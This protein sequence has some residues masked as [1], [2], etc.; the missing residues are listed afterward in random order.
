LNSLVNEQ[1]ER[2]EYRTTDSSE[3]YY[4]SLANYGLATCLNKFLHLTEN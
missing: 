2:F 4:K 3:E 1:D